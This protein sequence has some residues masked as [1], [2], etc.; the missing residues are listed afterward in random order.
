MT[1]EQAVLE[2]LLSLAPVTALVGTRI[3]QLKLRQGETLPA[4]RVQLVDDLTSAHLR[5]GTGQY[6]ARVQVDAFAAES[7]GSDPYASVTSVADAIHGDDAGSAL[8]GWAGDGEDIKIHACHRADRAVSYDGD[9]L[10]QVRC[11]QDYLLHW[12]HD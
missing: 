1:P 5:G 6:V 8:S 7:S 2:R 10:R 11:R 3:R 12:S 4:V 9:E